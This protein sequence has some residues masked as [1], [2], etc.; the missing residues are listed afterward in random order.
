MAWD[1]YG[2]SAVMQEVRDLLARQRWFFAKISGRR[3]IGKTTLIQRA[4][5]E[6]PRPRFYLQIPDSSPAGV[7]EIA[8]DAFATFDVPSSVAAPPHSLPELAAGIAKM[9]RAG[10]VVVLDEFQYFHRKHL[11]EFTSYLQGVVDVLADPSSQ[12]TGGLFVLGS[13]HTE[14][15]K[16][17]H[18]R[19]APLFDRVTHPIELAHLDIASV[20][21]MLRAHVDDVSS[22]RLLFLWNLFEGVPKFYRD[23]WEQDALGKARPELL[24][25]MFFQSSAPLRSEADNW[26]LNELR[27]RYDLV[28]RYVARHP[29]CTN[30]AIEAHIRELDRDASEQAA[31]YLKTLVDRFRMI[32]RRQPIFARPGSKTS[33]YY[34]DDNFLRTWLDAIARPVAAIHFRTEAE[35]VAM[36]DEGLAVSE[37]YGL[38]KLVSTLYEER[39]RK[40]LAGFR[41]TARIQGFWDR[42]GTELDLVALDE[43]T[44]TIRYG[45][46]KRN[47]KN[48]RSSLM[49]TQAHIQRFLAAYPAYAHWR[50]Q[51]VAIAPVLDAATRAEITASGWIPEDLA[52]LTRDL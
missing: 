19:N 4:L 28:L 40:G 50:T 37:G 49:P 29:G 32:A 38:E 8:H 25:R 23:A 18:D 48:L 21:E 31:G 35:L 22:A 44:R 13:L 5:A 36:A 27:G 1:F 10:Y 9:I 43:D 47:G 26:F 30:G 16:L 15:E 34:V 2:R 42:N 46:I 11:Y 45:S 20:L 3:R 41:L 39:S 24:Q 12:V 52:D 7:L 17:L 33:R 51:K 14:M 6:H